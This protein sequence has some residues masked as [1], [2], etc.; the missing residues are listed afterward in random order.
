MDPLQIVKLIQGAKRLSDQ[1]D[2]M[3]NA[4]SGKPLKDEKF[5]PLWLILMIPGGLFVLF[6]A[7]MWWYAIW[8]RH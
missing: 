4:K 6:G 7:W 5:N 2:R 8:G 1:K 3:D